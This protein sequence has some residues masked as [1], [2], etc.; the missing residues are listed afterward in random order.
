MGSIARVAMP[1]DTSKGVFF[2][3]L[4]AT[5]EEFQEQGLKVEIQYSTSYCA[6]SL[7]PIEYSALVIGRYKH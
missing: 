1:N 2:K 3:E 7:T 5:I 4:K 6:S